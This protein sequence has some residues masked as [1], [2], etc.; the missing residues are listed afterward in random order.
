MR[1]R[2]VVDGIAIVGDG[3]RVWRLLVVMERGVVGFL[4]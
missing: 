1:G 4:F 2:L 3:G